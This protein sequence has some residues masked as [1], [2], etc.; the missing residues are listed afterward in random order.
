[1]DTRSPA[2]RSEIMSLVKSQNTSPELAVRRMLSARGYRYRLH[3]AN[4]PGRP[5]IVFPNRRRALFIHGCFWHGHDCP[6]GH[7]PK[8]RRDYWV[9]KIAANKLR[10][11]RQLGRLRRAGWKAMV[12]WQC[13]LKAR[14]KLE[15]RI[16]R[17]LEASPR[18]SAKREMKKR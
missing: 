16:E 2:K 4:L 1:M 5:D 9:P 6:K 18:A 12:I 13:Q 11:A 15:R 3:P 7:P 14:E 10:D 17:F 8:S